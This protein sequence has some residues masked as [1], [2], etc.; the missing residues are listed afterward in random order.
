MCRLKAVNRS[1]AILC[2]GRDVYYTRDG[3][4]QNPKPQS[5]PLD[6]SV[7]PI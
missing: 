5:K 3:A 7:T 6:S 1:W 4:K 2:A